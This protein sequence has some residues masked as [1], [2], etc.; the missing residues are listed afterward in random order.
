MTLEA[1]ASVRT[2]FEPLAGAVMAGV[3]FKDRI[4]PT[5]SSSQAEKTKTAAI[6]IEIYFVIIVIFFLLN[7]KKHGAFEHPRLTI[8]RN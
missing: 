5:A 6:M 4:G 8:F 2:N 3:V 7:R 1:F